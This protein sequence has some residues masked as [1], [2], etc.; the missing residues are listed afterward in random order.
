[1]ALGGLAAIK[2]WTRCPFEG[3]FAF[4]R[5]VNETRIR[6]EATESLC[7]LENLQRATALLVEQER[8]MRI[9]DRVADDGRWPLPQVLLHTEAN[10]AEFPDH[11]GKVSNAVVTVKYRPDEDLSARG[12]AEAVSALEGHGHP[13]RGGDSPLGGRDRTDWR[14]LTNLPVRCLKETLEKLVTGF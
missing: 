14:L 12:Q 2:C 10:A 6:I 1:L 13:R 11:K 7:W 5:K 8:H 9:A 3:T 4:E